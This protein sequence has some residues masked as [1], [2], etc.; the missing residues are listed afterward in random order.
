MYHGLKFNR[1][2]E[3]DEI[4]GQTVTPCDDDSVD[5]YYSWGASKE[6]EFPGLSDLLGRTL[7]EAFN[8]DRI[9]LEAQHV[10]CRERPDRIFLNIANDAG[11]VKMMWV[12]D[13]LLHEEQ[14]SAAPLA[15]A[16]G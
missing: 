16:S 11:P 2:G 12:L 7:D 6:T 5:Y 13:K 1:D 3:R 15:L 8:E 9:I 4:P 10:R 14:A